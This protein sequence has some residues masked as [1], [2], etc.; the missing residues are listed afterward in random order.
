MLVRI[1]INYIC[2]ILNVIKIQCN[3]KGNY[4]RKSKSYTGYCINISAL[5]FS[6][7]ATV[8]TELVNNFSSLG[9]PFISFQNET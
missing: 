6:K 1:N 4:T 8:Q 7:Y 9:Y 2:T 3:L 5:N